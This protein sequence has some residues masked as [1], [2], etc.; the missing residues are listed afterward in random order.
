LMQS[1]MIWISAREAFAC[2][3]VTDMFG[4]LVLVIGW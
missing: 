4:L 3:G 2:A 1:A